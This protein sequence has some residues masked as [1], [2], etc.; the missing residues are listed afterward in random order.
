VTSGP[1]YPHSRE[2][3]PDLGFKT[4][5]E[6]ATAHWW[7][8]HWWA[9]SII[10]RQVWSHAALPAARS[11][12]IMGVAR[13]PLMMSSII[14]ELLIDEQSNTISR[15][16]GRNYSMMSSII[17]ELLIVSSNTR[18]QHGRHNCSSMSS[19]MKELLMVSSIILKDDMEVTTAHGWAV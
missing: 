16:G 11:H 2:Q 14:W 8:A 4:E 1:P 6:V 9:S 12:I 10:L 13:M 5:M 18:R 3:G 19:I 17:Q 7:A 15:H